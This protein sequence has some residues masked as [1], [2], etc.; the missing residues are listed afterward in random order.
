MYG[1]FGK[2]IWID[3]TKGEIKKRRYQKIYFLNSWEEV[4]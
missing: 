1:W 4:E 3:L 2:Q